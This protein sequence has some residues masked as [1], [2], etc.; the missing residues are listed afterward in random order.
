VHFLFLPVWILTVIVIW[1]RSS[2]LPKAYRIAL[3]I[4]ITLAIFSLAEALTLYTIAGKLDSLDTTRAPR[5]AHYERLGS[6]A[7]FAIS[8]VSYSRRTYREENANDLTNR[9]SQ[10]L[11]VVLRKLMVER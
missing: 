7:S 2:K 10:P 5:D 3:V 6:C 11:A 8:S 4:F 9:W 1:R